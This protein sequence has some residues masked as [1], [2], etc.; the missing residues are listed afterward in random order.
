[1][2]CFADALAQEDLAEVLRHL[3]AFMA[4]ALAVKRLA[5]LTKVKAGNSK[6]EYVQTGRLTIGEEWSSREREWRSVIIKI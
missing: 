6:R 3:G 2:W 4:L 5:G 1:M